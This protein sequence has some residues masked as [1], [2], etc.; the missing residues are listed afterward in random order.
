MTPLPYRTLSPFLRERFGERVQKITLDAGLTCPH[1]DAENK[2]G[3]I[4]CNEKGSGTGAYRLGKSLK[5]QIEE[6]ILLM[7][8]RYGARRFIAYF[9]SYTNT[10]G[11]SSVLKSCY[12]SVLAYPQIAGISIGTRPDCMDEERL[13][14][15]AGYSMRYL[16]WVEYGLQSGNDETLL[17]I[18]RGHDVK[19][20]TE[21]VKL[22]SR[23]NLRQCAHVIIGLPG[24]GMDDYLATARLISSLPVTDIKIHLLYV[25]KNTPLADML[26]AGEYTP[27]SLEE[28][29][30]AVVRFIANLRDDIIVQ[31]ITGDPHAQELIEPVWALQKAAVR[32]AIHD[33]FDRTGTT[34]GCE[35]VQP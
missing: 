4:Y 12:D 17:R 19:T 13:Q 29:A 22:T 27:L 15:I 24:E 5:D 7:N 8:R 18:N 9:Q 28:Y 1:R 25:A 11:E 33:E 10:Y 6:Q 21:A 23:F 30:A 31:R 32:H 16:V 3:C 34:Q 20:F 26:R 2:G 35:W 14:L